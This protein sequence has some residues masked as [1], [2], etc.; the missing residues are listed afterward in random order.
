MNKF[1]GFI[2]KFHI[3]PYLICIFVLFIVGYCVKW[4]RLSDAEAALGTK[5]AEIFNYFNIIFAVVI[6][7]F[8]VIYFLVVKKISIEKLYVIA[9]FFVGI[10]FMLIITPY[11]SS[12]EDNHIFKCYDMVN[13]IMGSKTYDD[14][15]YHWLR[16]CDANNELDREVSMKNYLYVYEHFWEKSDSD[17]MVL[18]H[19]DDVTYDTQAI[20]YYFPAVAG[21]WLGRILNLGTVATYMLGRLFI[22]VVYVMITY[23][24]LKKIPVFKTGFALIMLMPSTIAK[25]AC[26]SYDGLL[27]AYIFLFIA[28]SV[29]YIYNKQSLKVKDIVILVLSGLAMTVGKGGAYLPFLL[30]LFLIPKT[31]FGRKIPYPAVVAGAIAGSLLVYCLYNMEL[32]SD[33]AQSG[34][35][36]VND[37]A[38]TEEEGYTLKY[39]LT[40]PLKSLKV[41]INTFIQFGGLRY[42][43]LIGS[44]FGW[45]KVY[46]S[47]FYVA[48][49]TLILVIAGLNVNGEEFTFDRKQKILMGGIVVI[50]SLLVIVSMWLFWTPINYPYVVGVQGRYFIPMLVLVFFIIKNKFMTIKKNISNELILAAVLVTIGIIY[51][52]WTKMLV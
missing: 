1:K 26:V 4:F 3:I 20:I 10:L 32:F 18:V 49:Y 43:E 37:L 35:G 31:N 45:L 24:A 23:F 39:I 44:G 17:E 36:T 46:V 5:A 9:A 30:L 7:G 6:I 22:L 25:A 15:Q 13:A 42:V 21:I 38:W 19:V 2:R 14:P 28:Y 33:V 52:I 40:N 47:E 34:Q 41:F 27:M 51:D 12:D 8:S 11:A 29:Y 48:A 50:S 16:A